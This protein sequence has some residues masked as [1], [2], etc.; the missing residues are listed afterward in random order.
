MADPIPLIQ[1]A[2]RARRAILAAEQ[3]SAVRLA[4]AY[5]SAYAKLE[6]DIAT[7]AAAIAEIPNPTWGQVQRMAL[8]QSL[9]AQIAEQINRYAVIAENEISQ[10]TAESIARALTDTERLV[11]LA[12]PGIPAA[13]VKALLTRLNPDAVATMIGFLDEQSP[14]YVRLRTLGDDVA[15]LVADQ[16]RQGIILGYNPRRVQALI[17]RAAGQGLTWSLSSTRTA[18]L[19]AYRLTSH[20]NYQANSHVVRGWVWWA[21][22]GDKRTCMS[23]VNMHGSEH[24]LDEVLSDHHAGRCTPLPLTA[25]YRDLGFAV[26]EPA[27]TFERGESVFQRLSA[28]EQRE[29]M[30]PAMYAAWRRGA[31]RFGDLTER[32]TD[33]VYGEMM[34]EASLKGLLGERARDFYRR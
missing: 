14:L 32:Y 31:V 23:C 29:R 4:R 12:L 34:R 1:G 8:Y 5:A 25:S 26:D 30:G 16:L 33:D 10:T 21:Q 2:E 27:Q 9:R 19:W 3:A 13:E 18:N 11:Q 22:V 7:L 28:A 17:Q 20:A 15:A 24:G 6:Q